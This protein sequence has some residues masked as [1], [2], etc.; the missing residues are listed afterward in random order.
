MAIPFA[1]V[2]HR[3]RMK[4]VVFSKLFI[5]DHTDKVQNCISMP[6]LPPDGEAIAVSLLRESS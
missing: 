6:A 5:F 2:I 1:R 4:T 3:A